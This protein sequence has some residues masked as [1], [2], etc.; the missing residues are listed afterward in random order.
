MRIIAV[1]HRVKQTRSGE[2]RPTQVTIHND[3]STK[4]SYDLETETDELD[5]LL[6]R[7]PVLYRAYEEGE[8][9]TLFRRHHLK[10]TKVDDGDGGKKEVVS[11]VPVKY[12]GLASGDKVV[13]AL[14]G[15][16]D[17]F[18]FALSK[19]GEFVGASVHRLPAFELNQR[20]GERSKDEDTDTLVE[21]FRNFPELFYEVGPRDRDLILVKEAF[22]ARREAQ[23]ARIGCDQRLTSRVNG[24][25]FLSEEGH[26]PEG[27]IEDEADAKKANDMIL[28]AL[29]KEEVGRDKELKV[30]VHRL[31]VWNGVF[32][33]IKG[34]GEVIAA[35]VIVAVGDI[36]RFKTAPKLKRFLGAHVDADGRFPRR[37]VGEVANWHPSGRQALYLLSDQFVKRPDSEWGEKYR[38][39]KKMLREK[40]P[41][42][43][44]SVCGTPWQDCRRGQ[45][46]VKDFE[47]HT[48]RYTDGH[49]HKM[50]MKK[51]TTKFVEM[52]WKKWWELERA[53]Q[54]VESKESAA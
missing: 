34:V 49:I 46:G 50:A 15:S 39:Y 21:I 8:D 7:F 30:I 5:F 54:G 9:L 13:M 11:K 53:S 18:A 14:G 29:I 38:E 51:A 12:D 33:S 17:R 2:A 27:L 48:R 4:D 42:P 28:Q 19:R 52:L 23:Q 31:S 44:C 25:T 22:Y 47:K 10:Y 40:H 20:R 45:E 43:E 24:Q 1:R 16:G 3:D 36:R 35:G 41:V 6:G 37:R 26:Y 32:K